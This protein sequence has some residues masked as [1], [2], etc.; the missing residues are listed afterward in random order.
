MN[1][2]I[3][4]G[5]SGIGDAVGAVGADKPS[6]A[7]EGHGGNSAET[8]AASPNSAASSTVGGLH[9][10]ERGYTLIPPPEPLPV[11]VPT[12]FRFRILGPERTPWTRYERT[13]AYFAELQERFETGFDP[14]RS[15]LPDAGELRSP[16]GLF[17]VA[18]STPN[19]SAAS[20]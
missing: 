14:A 4:V 20:A 10:S 6:R 11:G 1:T 15:L 9:A 2:A 7:H 12:D 16:H 19:P 5:A 17:L 13:H 8:T 3:H 18:R